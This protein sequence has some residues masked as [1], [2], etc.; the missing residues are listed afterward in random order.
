MDELERGV[1]VASEIFHEAHDEAILDRRF[2]DDRGNL[3]LS[4]REKG[5][6]A[7]LPTNEIIN[8]PIPWLGAAGDGDRLLQ[9]QCG[10]V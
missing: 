10:N 4:K 8:L 7:T 9:A 1:L 3:R 2:D 6:H 5:F